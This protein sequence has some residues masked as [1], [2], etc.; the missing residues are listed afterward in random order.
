MCRCDKVESGVHTYDWVKWKM[1]VWFV[2]CAS[3]CQA[4]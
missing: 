4:Y 3:Y 1:E 2:C